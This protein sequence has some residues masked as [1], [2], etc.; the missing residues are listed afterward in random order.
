MSIASPVDT[1]DKGFW[2]YERK[3]PIQQKHVPRSC[4]IRAWRSQPLA[5]VS[6]LRPLTYLPKC[7]LSSGR[8]ARFRYFGAAE[9]TVHQQTTK[10]LAASLVCA[11]S[12]STCVSLTSRCPPA[13]ARNRFRKLNS[14]LS[15]DQQHPLLRKPARLLTTL[16]KT[17]QPINTPKV[18]SSTCHP[19]LLTEPRIRGRRSRLLVLGITGVA[20]RDS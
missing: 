9:C 1:R 2:P 6:S 5:G 19:N 7:L 4:G 13:L 8:S 10:Y 18:M 12:G 14:S 16:G 15:H 20:H 3:L 17:A 11:E